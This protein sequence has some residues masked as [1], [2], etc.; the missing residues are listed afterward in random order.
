MHLNKGTSESVGECGSA[1]E[2][3]CER[4]SACVIIESVI[5]CV[6]VSQ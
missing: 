6:S 1:C 2:C 3:K 5:S 4:V